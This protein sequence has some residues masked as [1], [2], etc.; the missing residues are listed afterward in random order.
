MIK[1]Y[2]SLIQRIKNDNRFIKKEG[3]TL[4]DDL[5]SFKTFLSLRGYRNFEVLA[6]LFSK[7]FKDPIVEEVNNFGFKNFFINKEELEKYLR[8]ENSHLVALVS[9]K[10][11][12][13]FLDN[14]FINQV[15]K[16][17]VC[18]FFD[19]VQ[20]PWNLGGIFRNNSAF[21]IYNTI[22]VGNCVFPFNP[23]VIRASKGFVF[24]QNVKI[25]K[26]E[27]LRE[28][29]SDF[30][31]SNYKV[32]CLENKKNS[33]SITKIFENHRKDRAFWVF[34]GEKYGISDHLKKIFTNCLSVRIDI[35]IE[36]L[37]LFAVHSIV[38]FLWSLK[39]KNY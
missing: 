29:L 1:R 19:N 33:V 7:D 6:V 5:E 9:L 39:M 26:R 32:Y 30:D 16:R 13:F 17:K 10:G 36:S 35:K 21:G 28:F 2:L 25:I 12:N 27:H 24:E 8:I 34:G 23:R 18:L 14:D 11:I 15:N 37:N 31:S 20:N 4:I 22:L 38:A 3:I